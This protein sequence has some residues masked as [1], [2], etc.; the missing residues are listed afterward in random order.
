MDE[1][2]YASAPLSPAESAVR[3]SPTASDGAEATKTLL[4]APS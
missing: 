2:R 1:A 3:Q 4:R